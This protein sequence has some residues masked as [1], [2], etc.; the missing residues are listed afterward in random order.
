MTLPHAMLAPSSA[1]DHPMLYGSAG[2]AD[3]RPSKTL[4]PL[5]GL[6]VLTWAA[7][8]LAVLELIEATRG[9]QPL[10]AKMIIACSA[11]LLVIAI[12]WLL[13]AMFSP[14]HGFGRACAAVGY[15]MLSVIFVSSGFTFYGK[16]LEGRLFSPSAAAAITK[17][18]ASL[19]AATTRLE[20][21]RDTLETL[22]AIA[23]QRAELERSG[24]KS[25]PNS[26]AGPAPR[27][28]M[29]EAEAARFR[30]ASDFVKTR[31]GA[32]AADVT[33][34]AAE[35]QRL[36]R[37]DRAV[38]GDSGLFDLSRKLDQ[39]VW[40]VN[41]LRTDPQLR[42]IRADLS[43]RAEKTTLA[44]ASGDVISCPDRQLQAA[45]RVAVRAFDQLPQ[46]PPPQIA[47]LAGPQ[48]TSAAFRRLTTSVFDALCWGLPLW[49][50]ALREEQ[51]KAVL[52]LAS[53]GRTGQVPHRDGL[54][55]AGLVKADAEP[56]MVAIL[57]DCGLLLMSMGRPLSRWRADN[58]GRR[59]AR[60]GL[61]A[62]LRRDVEMRA[63]VKEAPFLLLP[64]VAS[65][66]RPPA[67]L[68][69]WPPPRPLQPPSP[70]DGSDGPAFHS[71][72]AEAAF[73]RY[74]RFVQSD[75]ASTPPPARVGGTFA[76]LKRSKIPAQPVP[77][78]R[79]TDKADAAVAAAKV[80]PLPPS[81]GETISAT[82]T[83]LSGGNAQTPACP[84]SEAILPSPL[85]DALVTLRRSGAAR[86]LPSRSERAAPHETTAPHDDIEGIEVEKISRWFKRVKQDA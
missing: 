65:S 48:A 57:V 2:R 20:Q 83:P 81:P 75:K 15:L 36:T 47:S 22:T 86:P 21:L 56:L 41:G 39:A 28:K 78:A 30:V 82:G 9:D 74:A 80:C 4:V 19:L 51:S 63:M 3:A 31:V 27:R 33:A 49:A 7:S 66:A 10:L 46:L 67:T 17:V 45:L 55:P 50:D 25:C 14:I 64:R 73:G 29:R 18:H 40:A 71:Q 58:R 68:M 84:V 23:A 24:G 16:V 34:L 44:D 12:V 32:I 43:D 5:A 11:A 79:V 76:Y 61:D 62:V 59:A 77:P 53:Q 70:R 52:L 8:S 13:D 42:Q 1:V 26:G 6:G 69:Q 85:Q 54:E 35:V 72:A 38:N 60:T 37:L